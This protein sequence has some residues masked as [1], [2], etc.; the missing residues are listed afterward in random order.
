MAAGRD[1]LEFEE[2]HDK[3]IDDGQLMTFPVSSE[4]K[5]SGTQSVKVTQSDDRYHLSS[6][7]RI[8]RWTITIINIYVR[9]LAC[10]SNVTS[11]KCWS[12][13]FSSRIINRHLTGAC[14]TRQ[15]AT[16]RLHKSITWFQQW[17]DMVIN[18]IQQ[19]QFQPHCMSTC[20]SSIQ[21]HYRCQIIIILGFTFNNIFIDWQYFDR[22]SATPKDRTRSL[23]SNVESI[24]NHRVNVRVRAAGLNVMN[25]SRKVLHE[26][27]TDSEHFVWPFVFSSIFKRC[28]QLNLSSELTFLACDGPWIRSHCWKV[29]ELGFL[30]VLIETVR[31][32]TLVPQ[33]SAHVEI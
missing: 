6:T 29:S 3:P 20:T 28:K 31:G 33:V 19:L 16:K 7:Y 17:I 30:F 25:W 21:I 18:N 15:I 24:G 9:S 1:R 13:L 2:F 32:H 12:T 11:I 23:K 8:A 5:N 4:M 14:G 10:E 22:V 27:D 26:I